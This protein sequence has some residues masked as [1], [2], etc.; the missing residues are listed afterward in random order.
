MIKILTILGARPQFIKAGF[1][2]REIANRQEINEVIV[3]TEQHYDA[4]MSDI[5]FD[6]IKIP[7]S[8]YSLG[9]GGK[10]HGIMTGQMI[11]KIEEYSGLK[12]QDNNLLLFIFTSIVPKASFFQDK[13]DS[14]GLTSTFKEVGE[15]EDCH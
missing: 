12:N 15:R 6:E 7:K 8:D 13:V 1:V 14:Y 4:N 3:H 11:E 9:I 2:S 5:F 10:T